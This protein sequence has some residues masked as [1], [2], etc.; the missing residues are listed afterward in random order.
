MFKC[1]NEGIQGH[2]T[3]NL[4]CDY[5]VHSAQFRPDS[6]AYHAQQNVSAVLL[7]LSMRPALTVTGSYSTTDELP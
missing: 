1:F 6:P 5:S 7:Q 4:P 2:G 3:I